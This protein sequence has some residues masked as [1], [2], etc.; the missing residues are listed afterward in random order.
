MNKV[1]ERH[2]KHKKLIKAVFKELNNDESEFENIKKHEGYGIGDNIWLGDDGYVEH[3]FCKYKKEIWTLLG[4]FL[5]PVLSESYHKCAISYI[6]IN[7]LP[8]IWD[9][10]TTFKYVEKAF[11]ERYNTEWGCCITPH[12]VKRLVLYTI[13]NWYFEAKDDCDERW[14]DK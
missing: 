6:V 9:N 2:P 4:D 10:D 14:G 12:I 3:F 11:F 7:I 1:I 8:D 13:A 5:P